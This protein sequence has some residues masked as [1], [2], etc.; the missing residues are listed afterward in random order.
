MAYGTGRTAKGSTVNRKSIALVM[1]ICGLFLWQSCNDLGSS[2]SW[3]GW[4]EY[5]Y[6]HLSFAVPQGA[7]S[8]GPTTPDTSGKWIWSMDPEWS[9]SMTFLYTEL[10]GTP[11]WPRPGNLE[12]SFACSGYEGTMYT[13]NRDLTDRWYRIIILSDVG[14]PGYQLVIWATGFKGAGGEEFNLLLAEQVLAS[15]TLRPWKSF[16]KSTVQP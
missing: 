10:K 14:D 4:P 7:R 2:P 9:L 8:F 5:R 3:A 11:Y 1:G 6:R 15:M 16:P 12:Q 13:I